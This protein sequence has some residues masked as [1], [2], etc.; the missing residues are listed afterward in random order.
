MSIFNELIRNENFTG[1]T[2]IKTERD[3]ANTPTFYVDCEVKC[4]KCDKLSQF[5]YTIFN[6]EYKAN[7]KNDMYVSCGKCKKMYCEKCCL[8]LSNVDEKV[9]QKYLNLFFEKKVCDLCEYC[10]DKQY[11]LVEFIDLSTS[12]DE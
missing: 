6:E 2:T 12:S 3:Y 1:I 8:N 9:H 5:Q 4:D 10:Y 7:I 11:Y